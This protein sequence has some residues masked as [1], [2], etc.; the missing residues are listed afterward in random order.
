MKVVD[1][2]GGIGGTK[3]R[4]QD[5]RSLGGERHM[6]NGPR[7][8]EGRMARGGHGRQA[9][10]WVIDR[11]DAARDV[12]AHPASARSNTLVQLILCMRFACKCL[13]V[14]SKSSRNTN[15]GPLDFTDERCKW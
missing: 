2:P 3:V 4:E 9:L 1:V 15:K 13:A 5:G 6:H 7:G 14:Q 11:E 10:S 12:T 8:D